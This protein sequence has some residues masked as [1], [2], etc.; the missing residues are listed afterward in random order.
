MKNR[1][2]SAV[3][4]LILLFSLTVNASAAHP[5]PDLTKNGSL[6]FEMYYDK[7]PLNSGCLNLYKVGEITEE[8]QNFSFS[9]I[10][11]FED[12]DVSFQ[13]INDPELAEK[14]LELANKETV[15][16]TK[17]TALIKDGKAVFSD[18]EPG[19]YL[20]W[21]DDPDACKDLSPIAPFLISIPRYIDGEYI[22]DV[23][24]TPKNSPKPKPEPPDTPPP[25]D[26]PKTGQLNW[27][28]PLMAIAGAV[29]FITGLILC[30]TRKRTYNEE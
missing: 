20:V 1:I 13:D 17:L 21:Q 11:C 22:T 28:V 7:K 2:L 12:D 4:A 9:P 15:P 6:T 10:A 5:V 14:L 23:V 30:A 26:L 25:P 18:L 19:L 3:L 24:A 8:D 27:P 16:L 29:L